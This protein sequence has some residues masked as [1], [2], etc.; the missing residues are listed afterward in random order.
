MWGT[1]QEG[2]AYMGSSAGTNVATVSIHTTNDMPII[3]P[4]SLQAIGLVPFNINPH[5]V[6]P[7]PASTHMGVRLVVDIAKV[8]KE[9]RSNLEPRTS[10]LEPRTSNFEPRTSKLEL[11]TSN[12]ELRTTNVMLDGVG[13]P[14]QS[15]VD[16]RMSQ[17]IF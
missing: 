17:A 14:I 16:C 9:G 2:V 3:H 8:N 13:E 1:L 7:D 5:Y 15:E 11:R 6:E 4:P 12:F 10:K